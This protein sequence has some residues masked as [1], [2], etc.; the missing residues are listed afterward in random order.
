MILQDADTKMNEHFLHFQELHK[1]KNGKAGAKTLDYF[2][3]QL[4]LNHKKRF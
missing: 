4:K 2:K 3:K 1:Q